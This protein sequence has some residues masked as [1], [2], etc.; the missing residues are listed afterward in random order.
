MIMPLG[1]FRSNFNE[2][3][4]GA[5]QNTLETLPQ[6]LFFILFSGLQYPRLAAS[7]GGV[8]FVGRALYTNGYATGDPKKVWF[9]LHYVFCVSEA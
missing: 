9:S 2:N 4:T 3:S 1:L 5:H 8:W 7:L 6:T